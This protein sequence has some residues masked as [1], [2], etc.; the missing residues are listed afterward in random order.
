MNGVLS[1]SSDLRK[2]FGDFPAEIGAG[3]K[4]G[5]AQTFSTTS[6]NAV[7][8]AFAPLEEPEI[9]VSCVIERGAN[10]YNASWAA[11]EVLDRYFG[12]VED[13]TVN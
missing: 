10:G 12:L 4:T 6:N 1:S 8:V 11:R 7:F 5:T 3:G 13:E 9:V 2:A